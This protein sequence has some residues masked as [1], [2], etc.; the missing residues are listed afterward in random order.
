LKTQTIPVIRTKLYA[1]SITA[2]HQSRGRLIDMMD[3]AL[4]VPLVLVSA[5]AGYGKTVLV[6]EWV[7]HLKQPSAWLSLDEGDG[8]L[9][10]FLTYLIAA[11]DAES[12]G[13]CRA[14]QSLLLA[15][16]PPPLA[17]VAS[18]LI[19]DLD[20][21]DGPYVIALDDYHH[22]ERSSLVHELIERLLAHPPPHLH[23]VLITRRDPPLPLARLRA[24][25]R[26]AEVRLRD[27]QFTGQ[28]TAYLVSTAV[29]G[30]VS[31]EALANLQ[32]EVEGWAAALRLSLLAVRYA[33]DPDAA[34]KALHGGVPQ[35]QEYLLAEV[36][37]GLPTEVSECLLKSS[38]LNHFCADV[39]DAICCQDPQSGLPGLSGQEFVNLIQRDNL[40]ILSLDAEGR[41]FRYHHLF[42]DMLQ[43]Q[44]RQRSAS[45]DI[46]KLHLRACA[47]FD[48]NG[49]VSD[50]IEQ[51]L[52]AGRPEYAAEIVERRLHDQIGNDKWF[53]VK[54]WLDLLPLEI[55]QQRPG[56]L[57]TRAWVAYYQL[58]PAAVESNIQR[59][60]SLPGR[61]VIQ[62][63]MLRELDYLQGWLAFW[64]GD[65][66]TVQRCLEQSLDIF[67]KDPGMIAGEIRLYLAM[68]L[69]I[70]GED[71]TA[72]EFLETERA[73]AAGTGG[74]TFSIETVGGGSF[75]PFTRGP[76]TGGDQGGRSIR[77][78]RREQSKRP[79]PGLGALYTSGSPLSRL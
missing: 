72:L 2:G 22:L 5:P 45:N 21:I 9:R 15:P 25:N 63:M 62:P 53:V 11:I 60:Q 26:V 31:E 68:A 77:I 44:L 32:T 17:E 13:A 79:H 67:P 29:E 19:N 27:L 65:T 35:T 39:I 70:A 40:F 73:A 56:L 43:R 24:A 75:R 16:E 61:E 69:H 3:E 54:R 33:D 66:K 42:Q 64:T 4:E 41:W 8:D 6:S 47:W 34:L 46:E 71:E 58:E 48:T 49:Y 55:Q 37:G 74:G 23:I 50:S 12:P 10:Q 38:I 51:A 1:P 28:E 52:D 36:L 14:T 59:I 78:R 30:E 18:Y 76:T 57:L 20:D 7:R